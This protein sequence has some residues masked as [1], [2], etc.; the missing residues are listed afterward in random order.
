MARTEALIDLV[1]N[2]VNAT[3]ELDKVQKELDRVQKR[4]D[5]IIKK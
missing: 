3:K 1:L 2:I 5:K 4:L